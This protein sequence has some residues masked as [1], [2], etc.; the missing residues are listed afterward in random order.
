MYVDHGVQVGWQGPGETHDWEMNTRGLAQQI[1]NTKNK[2]NSESELADVALLAPLVTRDIIQLQKITDLRIHIWKNERKKEWSA[3]LIKIE[4]TFTNDLHSFLQ[5]LVRN[6]ERRRESHARK[7]KNQKNDQKF[8]TTKQRSTNILTCVGFAKT[9]LLFKSKQNC[10]A[11]LPLRLFVSSI[12]TAFN[13]P[14]PRTSATSGLL[15]PR[16]VERKYS[17]SLK[18]RSA[19]RSST[20]TERAVTATAQ[21]RG[22]LQNP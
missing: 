13:N 5:I 12:T 18:E 1:E 20:R 10:H 19:R 7:K 14:L 16:T 17:P 21:P 2:R 9:P 6:D 8:Q 15:N 11:V 22:L 3:Y 4:K